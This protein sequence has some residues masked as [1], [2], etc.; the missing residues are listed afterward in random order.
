MPRADRGARLAAIP[1]ALVP[2]PLRSPVVLDGVLSDER[3]A[4]LLALATEYP[5][6]DFKRTIDLNDKRQLLELV[7]DV[8]AMQLCGGYIL[9]GIGPDG[10]PTGDLDGH[11][12]KLF[13]EARLVPRLLR[14]LPEPLRLIT[15]I[16]EREGHRILLIYVERNPE[17]VV[18]IE[19]DGTY[20][21]AGEEKILFRRG[22]A[23]CRDG[24]RTVRI[25]RQGFEE[26][27]RGRVE[28]A[29]D[30]WMAEQR[31]IRRREQSEYEAA[32]KGSGPLGSVNLDLDQPALNAAALELLRRED[33]IGL[34]HLMSEA[35]GRAGRLIAG[36]A[37]EAELGDLLDRITCLAATFLAY[38]R[39]DAL[40]LLIDVLSR[41]YSMPL[42]HDA[43]KRL[44][45]RTSIDPAEVAPRVWLA[46]IRRV[47][48]L[49]ALAVRSENWEAVRMLTL[50]VPRA[51]D[52][53]EKNWLR[54]ALTMAARAQHLKE[55]RDGRTVEL[56]L[57][58]LARADA[59][60]LDCLRQDGV[61]DDGLLSSL[62]QFDVLSNLVA[63]DGSGDASGRDFYP[64]FARFYASRVNA[65]VHRM[66]LDPEMREL[67]F[68]RGD[69]DLALAL[70]SVGALARREGWLSDG[71]DG[72]E[73]AIEA[74]ITQNAPTDPP[75]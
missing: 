7:K 5:E 12:L 72:W 16:A 38:G 54:H 42:G 19:R 60:R 25:G 58:N 11:D 17:G 4:E 56:S 39:D 46:I 68:R 61:D 33:D 35:L 32:V 29:K 75:S 24:T 53:Y 23:F 8:A 66:L 43:A 49:G 21:H 27:I 10:R 31:E 74:F 63:I 22:D 9:A 55:H 51:M 62:A 13:D 36:G 70:R 59:A 14:W 6:L 3:I 2:D 20:E 34:T 37:V 50:Q 26:V 73:P 64:N 41:I 57:L 52:E 30:A 71:F 28:A 47:Y 44:A 45:F 1:S 40:T 48:A 67:L 65:I 18:F 15:R 69:Q